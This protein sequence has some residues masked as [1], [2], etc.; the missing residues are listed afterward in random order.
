[1]KLRLNDLK[2]KYIIAMLVCLILLSII[3]I[4]KV[5]I[6]ITGETII[7]KTRAVDPRDLFR[8]DYV[9]LALDIDEIG[10]KQISSQSNA[11]LYQKYR[12]ENN[13]YDD[14]IWVA[15]LEGEAGYEPQNV[16]LSQPNQGVY[17]KA[18]I[19]H[20]TF[21]NSKEEIE[22]IRVTYYID[23]YFVEENTGRALEDE[24]RN[25]DAYAK[26]KVKNGEAIIVEIVGEK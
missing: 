9:T 20:M 19:K 14:I 15:L 22:S 10:S 21:D 7:V 12:E 26:L 6:N 8:G 3:A 17:L 25:G 13:Y 16:Y 24:I 1:M 11:E 2:I 5:Y 18:Q 23:R 4:P